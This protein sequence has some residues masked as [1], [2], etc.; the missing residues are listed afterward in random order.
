M[1]RKLVVILFLGGVFGCYPVFTLFASCSPAIFHSPGLF[2]PNGSD[3]T[4]AT[5]VVFKPDSLIR[6]SLLYES[7]K[8]KTFANKPKLTRQLYK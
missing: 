6:D 4:Q 5:A 2:L 3:S 8:I 1:Y 7:T